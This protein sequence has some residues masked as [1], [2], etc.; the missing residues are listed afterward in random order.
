MG[1][2]LV[3]GEQGSDTELSQG[4]ELWK[5]TARVRVHKEGSGLKQTEK[6]ARG[7]YGTAESVCC[8]PW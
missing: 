4:L 6:P 2:E 3:P 1:S 8:Y 5:L 7:E